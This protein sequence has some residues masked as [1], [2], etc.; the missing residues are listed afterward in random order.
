MQKK[1]YFFCAD[2]ARVLSS[3]SLIDSAELILTI[4]NVMVI[5]KLEFSSF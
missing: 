3:E 5:D 2:Y 1:I 4:R